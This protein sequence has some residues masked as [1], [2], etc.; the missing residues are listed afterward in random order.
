MALRDGDAA[1][2]IYS[3]DPETGS[4]RRLSS[5][6]GKTTCGFWLPDGRFLYSST[7]LAGDDPPPPPDRSKGYVWPL[8]RT[9]ELFLSEEG[10]LLRLT[11]N[12]GYD[13][14]ATVSPDGAR[15][16]FTSH[17][18]GG[19]GLWT[20]NVD[21]SDLRK[22]RHRR[23]YAGGAFFSP[24]GAWIVYRAFYPDGEKQEALWERM[25]R[26]RAL[27]PVPMEVYLSR[28]DGSEE[29]ALTSGGKVNFAPAFHPDGARVIFTSDRDASE[30]GRYSLYLIRTDGTGLERVSFHPGFDGF[31]HFSPDGRRLAWISNRNARENPRREL[32]V[33]LADWVEH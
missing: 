6:K 22:V 5:G 1:D 8:Y 13:A 24:D 33:F 25:L 20:M 2:Q 29:R 7:H 19:I 17:R 11:E 21:G 23:G 28:P 15:I 30:P 12:D 27:V 26:E 18:E 14:E 9:F 3:L 31:P 10:R 4:L 32:N 16:I